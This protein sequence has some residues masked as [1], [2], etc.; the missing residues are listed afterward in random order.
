MPCLIRYKYVA[1]L[2]ERVIEV[3]ATTDQDKDDSKLI[4]EVRM[5]PYKNGRDGVP[6]SDLVSRLF[7]KT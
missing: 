1:S 2:Y 5:L 3:R 7:G 4:I 6:N